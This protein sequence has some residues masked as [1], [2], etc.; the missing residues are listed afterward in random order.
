VRL[1]KNRIKINRTVLDNIYAGAQ[2]GAN[3]GL[4]GNI[5]DSKM[6]KHYIYIIVERKEIK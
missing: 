4:K 5:I 3:M 1:C 6:T 2:G